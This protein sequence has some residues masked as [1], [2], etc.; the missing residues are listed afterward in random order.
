VVKKKI[1]AGKFI[2]IK[3]CKGNFGIVYIC[4]DLQTKKY[5]ALKIEK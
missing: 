4:S 3:N 5:A 2:P 1:C